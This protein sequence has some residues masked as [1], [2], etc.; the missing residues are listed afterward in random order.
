MTSTPSRRSSFDYVRAYYGVPARRGMR[1]TVDGKPGTI[2]RGDGQYI[3][4]RFD[5][6]KHSRC[7]HPMWRVIYE[8]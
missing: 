1:V 2:T 3:R 7:C 6:E 4:V 8:L 5:G